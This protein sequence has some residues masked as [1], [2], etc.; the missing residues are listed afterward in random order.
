MK[1]HKL[2]NNELKDGGATYCTFNS[3]SAGEV[4]LESF[5]LRK[6][7]EAL[8]KLLLLLWPPE[9]ELLFF[10][11]F[12]ILKLLVLLLGLGRIVK[13][14]CALHIRLLKRY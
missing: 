13:K 11:C 6:P 14:F 5:I 2:F 4:Q 9:I 8:A 1:L 3:K 12:L 10:S 7:A